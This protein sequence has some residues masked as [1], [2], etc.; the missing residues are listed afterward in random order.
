MR[1]KKKDL[2]LLEKVT[3]TDVAA[4][5]MALARVDDL[6]GWEEALG[7]GAVELTLALP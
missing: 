1:K 4:E 2:P 5:G 3:I 6:A 7:S